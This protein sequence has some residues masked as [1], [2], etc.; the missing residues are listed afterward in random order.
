MV[1]IQYHQ[2][3]QNRFFVEI[4][5]AIDLHEGYGQQVAAQTSVQALGTLFGY[6]WGHGCLLAA[7][8]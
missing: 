7:F 6:R 4:S 3:T 2:P 8:V 1:R 5:V